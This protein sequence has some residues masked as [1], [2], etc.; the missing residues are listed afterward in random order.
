MKPVAIHTMSNQGFSTYPSK[1]ALLMD[2]APAVH[3]FA[4]QPTNC[5]VLVSC[6][7]WTE[8]KTKY[9]NGCQFSVLKLML[10]NILLVCD[11]ILGFSYNIV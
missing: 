6:V 3:F 10:V 2:L 8:I 9:C 5:Q 4:T 7:K 11:P 1:Q